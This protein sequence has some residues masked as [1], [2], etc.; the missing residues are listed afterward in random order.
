M[1]SHFFTFFMLLISNTSSIVAQN[2]GPYHLSLKREILYAGGGVGLY[3]FGNNLRDRTP[4]IVLSDLELPNIP[5]FD[6]IATNY[7]S[8]S[9]RKA[10]DITKDFATALPL[11]LLIGRNSR[12]D[13]GKIAILFG[14]VL[15]INQGLTEIVKASALRPRPYVFAEDLPSTTVLSGN[16]RAAFLSGHTSGTAAAS[17]FFAKTFSDYYPD[18]RL[19]PYV[20]GTAIALPVLTGYFR[21]RAGQHY[22]SDVVAGYAL[23]A[24]VGY[25]VP[26]LHKR[27]TNKRRFTLSPGGEGI[28]MSYTFK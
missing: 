25:L 2:S 3:L 7:S 4:D 28:Y 8:G 23:G 11:T 12:K 20:W 10:S 1:K 9:A 22:P 19:K 13:A 6:R 24:A 15:L 21:V 14:E 18:S 16:D 17:F 27:P 5:R 26:A